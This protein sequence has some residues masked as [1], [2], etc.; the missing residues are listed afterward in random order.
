LISKD[1]F[2]APIGV[3]IALT[4]NMAG[5]APIGS[6]VVCGSLG[7]GCAT[8]DAPDKGRAIYSIA[9]F[10]AMATYCIPY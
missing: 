2:A 8:A 9:R 5:P 7:I 6:G 10:L 4:L 3:K 1:G